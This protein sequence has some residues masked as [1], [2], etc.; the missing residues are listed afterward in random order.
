MEILFTVAVV[1]FW[2]FVSEYPEPFCQNVR[3]CWWP[4]LVWVF[5]SRSYSWDRHLHVSSEAEALSCQ[6]AV[7]QLF[8]SRFNQVL[9]TDVV[10]AVRVFQRIECLKSNAMHREAC[11]CDLYISTTQRQRS[12]VATYRQR[13]WSHSKGLRRL[14]RLDAVSTS[15]RLTV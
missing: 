15:I 13:M 12:D 3:I 14:H 4:T 5:S 2:T 9:D 10:S 1:A 11:L 8:G 6:C 7:I